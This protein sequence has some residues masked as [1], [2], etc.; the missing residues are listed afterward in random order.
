MSNQ[1]K[2][3][4]P[5]ERA[6]RIFKEDD[7]KRELQWMEDLKTRQVKRLDT[8]NRYKLFLDEKLKKSNGKYSKLKKDLHH[9]LW[10]GANKVFEEEEDE[11]R[12]IGKYERGI[13]ARVDEIFKGDDCSLATIVEIAKEYGAFD[14]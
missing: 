7:E 8:C 2:P 13:F 3:E 1:Q 14:Y 6:I 5:E 12:F 11:Y 10:F 4:T 9:A